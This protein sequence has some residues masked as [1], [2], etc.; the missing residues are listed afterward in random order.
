MNN[1]DKLYIIVCKS[2]LFVKNAQDTVYQV[3]SAGIPLDYLEEL[4]KENPTKSFIVAEAL[5]IITLKQTIEIVR[6][7]IS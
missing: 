5:E 6:T 7:K 1:F 4:C 2:E 3:R